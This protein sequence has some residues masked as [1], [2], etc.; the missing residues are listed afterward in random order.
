MPFYRPFH[1][2]LPVD[3][4]TCIRIN[5]NTGAKSLVAA[6]P[7][8]AGEVV[9][10]IRRWLTVTEPS[11][12]TVQISETEHIYLLPEQL[13]YFNHSCEPNCIFD[14]AAMRVFTVRAIGASEDLTF[15]YP[16]TEWRM[17]SIF[18]CQCGEPYCLGSISG[19]H[20][21]TQDQRNRY[22]LNAHIVS[23]LKSAEN[24]P[25]QRSA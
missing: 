8:G 20:A 3:A 17:A 5:Y 10:D 25:E 6:Q 15:F 16:S 23:L 24:R 14:T 7:I 1:H 22:F 4:S 13:Q 11:Y 21:L 18:T 12:L 19:A 2:V 9:S